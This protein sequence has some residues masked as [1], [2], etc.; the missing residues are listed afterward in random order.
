MITGML[1]ENFILVADSYKV[2]H[3]NHLPKGTRKTHTSMVP[4]KHFVDFDNEIVIDEVVVLG[5]QVVAAILQSV[6]ITDE[7]ID[8]AEIEI[9]EQG[10]DFPRAEWEYLRDLGY[11]PLSVRALPEGTVISPGLPVMTIENTDDRSAWLPAYIE[12]WTQDIVWV[13]STTASK[14]RHLRKQVD[15][16]CTTTG[17]DYDAGEYMIHNFGDR[18]AGGRD[19]A[20]MAG[21]AHAVFFSG[22]DCLEANRYNKRLYNMTTPVLS[23]VDANEHS[24]VCANSDCENKDDSA[25]FEMTL[26]NLEKVVER[27]N[28]GIGIPIQSC[29]IDT[30][31]DERY[32]KDFVIPNTKRIAESGGKY[33]C[34]PDS[35]SAVHKPV[36]VCNWLWSGLLEEYKKEALKPR[37]VM[38][39]QAITLNPYTEW[40]KCSYNS[41]GYKVLPEYL[42]VIQ[43]DGLRLWDFQT[44]FDLSIKNNLAASNFAFGFGGGLTNGSGRDDFSF[45]M[46]ATARQT[47]EGVWESM[48]KQP[49]TDPGKNS[50]KGRVTVA[51]DPDGSFVCVPKDQNSRVEA[52]VTVYEDGGTPYSRTFDEVREDARK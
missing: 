49:K 22:S 40:N 17:T 42:G 45:S 4:R 30:F 18:G 52:M 44:I 23:S 39:I 14:V 48:Q 50:L 3:I 51:R 10:Y 5:P 19:R 32:I 29:L 33:V 27:T 2:G 28:R 43:G 6:V 41:S 36:E 13:M 38:G 46:K 11:L 16:F 47:A 25:A 37:E 20:I 21:I 31:D 7:M 8:E 24:T 12:T 26:A 1:E 34:R 15:E 9:T 35:G